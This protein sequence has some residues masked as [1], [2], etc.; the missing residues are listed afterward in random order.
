[1]NKLPIGILVSGRGSNMRAILEAIEAGVLSAQALVVISDQPGAPALEIA[2]QKG[3]EVWVI[4]RKSVPDKNSFENEIIGELIN[5]EV[6]LV[7]LAGFMR[8]LGSSVI[9]A[10]PD[11]IINVHPTLLP[12]LPGL[13]AQKQALNYGVKVAGCTVHFVNEIMDGGR[14]IFQA[15]VPVEPDDTEESLSARILKEEHRLLPQAVAW[16]AAT[17]RRVRCFF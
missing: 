3:V 9:K 15:C 14:I 13:H 11:R 6:E 7:I 1:M 12:A 2:R 10:F 4:E 5:R 16:F 17:C 8:V